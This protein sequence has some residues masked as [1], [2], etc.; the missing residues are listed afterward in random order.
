MADDTRNL[1]NE[2]EPQESDEVIAHS[3]D[4]DDD[5]APCNGQYGVSNA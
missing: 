1:E 5:D 2:P 4:A 3:A